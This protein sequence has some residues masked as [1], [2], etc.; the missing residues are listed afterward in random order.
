MDDVKFIYLYKT[1]TQPDFEGR[2]HFVELPVGECHIVY[3]GS[4]MCGTDKKKLM[5]KHDTKIVKLTQTRPQGYK[6][7]EECEK[8]YKA[9]GQLEWSKWVEKVTA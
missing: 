5:D 1:A 8:A 7:C 9:N 2:S 6:V 3:Q 4:V